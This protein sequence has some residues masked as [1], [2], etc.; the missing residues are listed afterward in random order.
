MS[1]AAAWPVLNQLD[2]RI[3]GVL[4]EKAKTTPD[5]YP[6]SLNSLV[7]GCNQKSNRDPVLDVD[8]EMVREAL[9]SLQERGL[10]I[11]VTGGRIDRWRQAL[12]EVWIVNK[13][14]LAVLTELL[15]R[16]PQTEGELRSRA[17]RMEPIDDLE[18]LRY[19]LQ[20]LAERKLVVYFSRPGSRGAMLTHGFHPPEELEHLR[21]KHGGSGVPDEPVA[22]RPAPVAVPGLKD[23]FNRLD[24][25]VKTLR[26]EVAELRATVLELKRAPGQS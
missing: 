19:L 16:G 17:S 20:Q 14:E 23:E 26:Q 2:R 15:L 22:A 18:Q 8:E 11:C 12:Y 7:A 21:R 25:D 3:L 5:V 13:T 10:V 1:D 4:V 6:M 9:E 24:N